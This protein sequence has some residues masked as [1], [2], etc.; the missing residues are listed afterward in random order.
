M[1]KGAGQIDT[2]LASV[3]LTNEDIRAHERRSKF[4]RVLADVNI[5][6]EFSVAHGPH[7]LGLPNDMDCRPSSSTTN[8]PH[9]I[10]PSPIMD[11]LEGFHLTEFT[12]T[13]SPSGHFS[14]P[15]DAQLYLQ[16]TLDE[17]TIVKTESYGRESEKQVWKVKDSFDI[18]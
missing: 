8:S 5:V 1:L 10:P 17:D 18:N 4:S 7:P 15:D 6:L 12:I 14:I 11:A 3:D 16:F 13:S 2:Q 9:P